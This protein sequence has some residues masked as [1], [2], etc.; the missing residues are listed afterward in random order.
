MALPVA[1]FGGISQINFNGIDLLVML[2]SVLLLFLF[3]ANDHKISKKEGF[4]F[5]LFF[6]TYYSVV[7]ING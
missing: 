5:L 3:S 7:I 6:I 2:L 1:I 4:L